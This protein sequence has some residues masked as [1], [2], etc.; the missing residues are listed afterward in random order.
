MPDGRLFVETVTKRGI[1]M[2]IHEKQRDL[3]NAQLY[4]EEAQSEGRHESGDPFCVLNSDECS[5][6]IGKN[7]VNYKILV[8]KNVV[9]YMILLRKNVINY[10]LQRRVL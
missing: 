10:M 7:V 5:F 3:E 6:L 9:N 1:Y 4:V 2:Q 8:R